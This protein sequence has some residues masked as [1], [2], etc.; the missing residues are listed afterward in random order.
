MGARL[1]GRTAWVIGG[2]SGL[3]AA[4]ALALAAEGAHVV[5]SGRRAEALNATAARI[6]AQGG[7]SATCRPLDVTAPGAVVAAAAA[8]GPVDILVYSSGT[9]VRRRA[10]RDIDPEGW[11]SVVDV[12]LNGAFAAAHAVLPAM[13]ARG[14]GVIMM[15]SSWA[16]WRLEPVAGAAYSATKRALLAFTEA[17][18]VE[19][20]PHGVRA[21]CI[22]PAEVDTEVL[23]TRPVPPSA[24]A[25]AQMLQAADIGALVGF[26]ATAPARMCVNEVVVSPTANS[27]YRPRSAA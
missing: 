15:I 20:G 14:D 23:D 18:N 8:I 21:S 17:I 6:A 3:G 10:L 24:E 26:I 25:R 5:V 16:G 11:H 22:C 19:E 2:G 4:A 9:N 27:F 7:G 1:A 12:N 13:R